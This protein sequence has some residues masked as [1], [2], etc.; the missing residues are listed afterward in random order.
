MIKTAF[1]IAA[2]NL[3]T[4]SIAPPALAQDDVDQR[5][6]MVHFAT[7]CNDVAQRRFDQIGRA[8]V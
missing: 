7:S 3:A 8:H 2:A 1:V 6:G 4:L 5:F